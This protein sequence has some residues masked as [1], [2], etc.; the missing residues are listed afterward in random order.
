[1]QDNRNNLDNNNLDNQYSLPT[2]FSTNLAEQLADRMGASEERHLH[3]LSWVFILLDNVFSLLL[4]FVVFFFQARSDGFSSL[5]T[6]FPLITILL[7]VGLLLFVSLPIFHFLSYRF[8]IV[9]GEF[10]LRWGIINKQQRHIPLYKIHNVAIK[11]NLLQRALAVAEVTLETAGS[12]QDSE[13]KLRVLSL[14]EALLIEE[15][16]NTYHQQVSQQQAISQSVNQS[17][18]QSVSPQAV[19]AQSA[20]QQILNQTAINPTGVHPINANSTNVSPISVNQTQATTWQNTLIEI[21]DSDI[22]RYGL[23]SNSGIALGGILT[24]IVSPE[25]ILAWLLVTFNIQLPDEVDGIGGILAYTNN[26]MMDNGWLFQVSIWLGISLMLIISMIILGKIYSV[27]M[28]FISLYDFKLSENGNNLTIEK[29]LLTRHKSNIPLEKI[30]VWRVEETWL[31]RLFAQQTL[32][33]DTA[34]LANPQ[35]KQQG[36]RGINE[37]IPIADIDTIEQLLSYWG[38]PFPEE[39]EFVP[40]HEKAFRRLIFIRVLAIIVCTLIACISFESYMVLWGVLAVVALLFS[41]ISCRKRADYMGLVVTDSHIMWRDGWLNRVCYIC[42]IPHAH[43][44]AI[45][46]SLFDRRYNMATLIID[47][48]GGTLMQARITM[49]YLPYEVAEQVADIVKARCH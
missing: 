11:Q 35:Q 37:L 12:G 48:V 17:A 2:D 46:H 45:T 49:R 3:P 40:V 33:L 31:H 23:I 10:R 18:N 8:Q 5:F 13:A 22:I 6:E 47:T 43:V 32:Q 25:R 34:I 16:I 14:Q 38:Q 30:Q 24:L 44:I 42:S 20:N 27:I 7:I 9:S 21:S 28:A 39:Y 36:E 19:N 4:G 41:W 29:G 1:M 26:A 15:A